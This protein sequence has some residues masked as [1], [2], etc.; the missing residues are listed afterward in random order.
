MAKS[1]TFMAPSKI[2][3]NTPKLSTPLALDKHIFNNIINY[4][5]H[6]YHL[7]SPSP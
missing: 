7:V 4:Q 3:S 5:S 1:L 2:L 6:P